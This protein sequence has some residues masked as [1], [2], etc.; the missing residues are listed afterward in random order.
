MDYWAWLRELNIYQEYK[1]LPPHPLTKGERAHIARFRSLRD[2]IH[3]GPLYTVLGDNA[4]V[5]K[6]TKTAAAAAQFDPFEGMPTYSHKY[7]KRRRKL[8]KL[9]T[10]PYVLHFF[11]PELHSTLDPHSSSANPPTTIP[12]EKKLHLSSLAKKSTLTSYD[13]SPSPSS[14]PA[15]LFDHLPHGGDEEE[16]VPEP[17]E[18]EDLPPEEDVDDDYD[19]DEDDMAGDYNAEQYFEDGGDDAG[20]DYD[21]GGEADG[22]EY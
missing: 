7:T 9:D 19:D 5:G 3:E 15:K 4:R 18:E 22:G 14:K 11:P 17:A 20:D 10:R 6:P 2:R 12:R 21:G 1:P 16:E 13:R 8:P